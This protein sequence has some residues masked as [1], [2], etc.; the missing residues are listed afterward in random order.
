[1][2]VFRYDNFKKTLG[3]SSSLLNESGVNG[4]NKF[5]VIGWNRCREVKDDRYII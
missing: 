3:H 1:M 2:H 4:Y 5:Y